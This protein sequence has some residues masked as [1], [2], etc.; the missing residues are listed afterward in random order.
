MSMS[1]L[2]SMSLLYAHVHSACLCSWCKTMSMLS[3]HVNA[4]FPGPMSI[5]HI[6]LLAHVRFH[7]LPMFHVIVY[8]ECPYPCCMF[9]SILH[10]H[11]HA[12]C[13]CP[14][15]KSMSTSMRHFHIHIHTACPHSCPY[16][17]SLQ[18]VQVHCPCCMSMS[19]LL[20]ISMDTWNT[21]MET[22]MDM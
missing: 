7:V 5:L 14:C 19:M 13:L 21:P 18:D 3:V 22:D 10:A 2:Q 15:C 16:W 4:S 6:R 17:I 11:V 9:M 8:A 12:T 20:S 1:L